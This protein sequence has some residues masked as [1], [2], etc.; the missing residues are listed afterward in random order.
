MKPLVVT[1]LNTKNRIEGCYGLDTRDA[2][3]IG[4]IHRI[5]C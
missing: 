1:P 5:F 2:C 3:R 4:G